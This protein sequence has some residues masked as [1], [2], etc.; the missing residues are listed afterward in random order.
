MMGCQSILFS[1][2]TSFGLMVIDPPHRDIDHPGSWELTLAACSSVL[3][4]PAKGM[5][6]SDYPWIVYP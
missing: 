3:E 6:S 5:L 2:T 1:G 4:H